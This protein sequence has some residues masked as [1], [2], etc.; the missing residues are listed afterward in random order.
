MK[1]KSE[2]IS[3]M[4]GTSV[5]AA[6]VVVIQLMSSFGIHVGPVAISLVLVPIAIG[7]ILYGPLAGAFLGG[8]F[9]VIVIAMIFAGMDPASMVM[10]QF[11]APAT[12]AVC[13]VKGIAA[14]LVCGLVYKAFEKIKKGRTGAVVGTICCPFVNTGIYV[15]MVITIFR[16]L[17]EQQFNVTGT[18]AVFAA[19]VGVIAVNFIS[20]L[21]TTVILVPVM[22]RI[23]KTVRRQRA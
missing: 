10:M 17:M 13:L 22:L 20:E 14:G 6:I 2:K 11:N 7:A 16:Q 1:S 19:L 12:I 21:V 23:I 8:V 18:S 5:L 9:G 4:V 15:L 3:R